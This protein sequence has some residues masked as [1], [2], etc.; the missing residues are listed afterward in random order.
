MTG[1]E[2]PAAG[3][4]ADAL[5]GFDVGS[6]VI[7]VAVGNR[8]LGTARALT[9]LGH[10]DGAPDWKRLDLLVREWQPQAFV[11]GLPLTLDGAEQPMSRRARDFAAVLERRYARPVH[12]VDERYTSREAARRFAERRARGALRRRDAEAID[13]LAAEIILEAWFAESTDASN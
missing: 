13:T 9:T 8:L 3:R 1:S 2:I 7:G 4:G 6:R 10:R 11:V 5:L 12:A